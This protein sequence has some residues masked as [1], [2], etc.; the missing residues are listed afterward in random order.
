ME[1]SC[2]LICPCNQKL[3]KSITTLKAH[4]KTQG[5]LLWETNKEQK[6]INIKINRLENENDH[7]RRLNIM[8]MERIYKLEKVR[9]Y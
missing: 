3:Y 4:H 1:I 9:E 2:Q 8:L 5:H 6:E 7:L